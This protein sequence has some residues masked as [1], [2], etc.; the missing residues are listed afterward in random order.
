LNSLRAE[1]LEELI[2]LL[3]N[4]LLD[5]LGEFLGLG[6]H[7]LGVL[8]DFSGDHVE[9]ILNSLLQKFNG[10][11]QLGGLLGILPG[12]VAAGLDDGG[13]VGRSTSVPCKDVLSVRWDVRQSTLGTNADDV[14][15]QLLGS[16]LSNSVGRVLG[17]LERQVVG[18]KTSDVWGSHG[19]TRDGVDCILGTNPGGLNAQAGGEDVVAL[20]EVGEVSAGIIESAST[21]SDGKIS[22]SWGVVARI[23]VVVTSGHSEVD[24]SLNSTIYSTVKSGRLATTER[25]VGGRALEALLSLL[26]LLSVCIGSPFDTLDNICHGSRAIGSEDLNSVDVGLLGNTIL[27]SSDSTGAVS[28]VS[29]S[30]LIGIVGRDSLAPV[31][32]ALEINVLIVGSSVN[33]IDI[34]TLSTISGIQV[35]VVIA[36]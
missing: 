32:S 5:L 17:R 20:S 2:E 10:G 34:N 19:S 29:V 25:H 23:G 18:Q 27:L 9:V 1:F 14:L 24:T 11:G 33:N 35:F 3:I 7:R 26:G 36:E 8:D 22:S 13:V 12:I 31:R 4:H 28:S 6:N 16:D 30:I 15:L 21:D